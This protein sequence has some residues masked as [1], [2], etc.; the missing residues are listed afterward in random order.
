M[1]PPSPSP[2]WVCGPDVTQ[3]VTAVWQK[4]KDD[5]AALTFLQKI[6]ACNSIFLP[7]QKPDATLENIL[8]L[9]KPEVS[10][11]SLKNRAQMFADINSWDTLPLYRGFSGWL[12]KPPIYDAKTK[13][14]CATPSSDIFPAANQDDNN[15]PLHESPDCCANSVQVG[16]KCWL[17]GTANYGT[18]GVMVRACQDF[19]TSN[20]L[21]KSTPLTKVYSLEWAIMLIRAYKRFGSEPEDPT[22]PIAWAEATYNGGPTAVP[23]VGGNRPKCNCGCGCKGDVIPVPWDYVWTPHK[24][25]P[26]AVPGWAVWAP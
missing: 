10:L 9:I 26:A 19:T 16:G 8:E 23:S 1:P 22:L 13:G 17:N 14:P 18:F 2:K 7:F 25:R 11:E 3:Q 20:P 24:M 6:H 21:L 12:R 4:I 5:F 15:D